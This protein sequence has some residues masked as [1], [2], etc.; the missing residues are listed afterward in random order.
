[1]SHTAEVQIEIKDAT[2]FR[3]A[4][5]R[6][7]IEYELNGEVMM[8]DGKTVKGMVARLE[9]WRYPAVFDGTKA[10]VDTYGERW[11]K[12]SELDK[13]KQIY[14][15]ESAKRAAKKQG[16]RVTEHVKADGTIRL[17]CSK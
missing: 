4:C 6:L 11:G 16:F 17:Q 1:M 13:F 2:A 3:K 5:E 7:K 12:N 14:A 10:Y 8:Y 15:A 9:G